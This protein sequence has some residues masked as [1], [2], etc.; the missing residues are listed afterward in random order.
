MATPDASRDKIKDDPFSQDPWALVVPMKDFEK[1]VN[2]TK[3]SISHKR[4]VR[5]EK[6]LLACVAISPRGA[7]WIVTVGQAET[8]VIWRLKDKP[9]TTGE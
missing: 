6:K 3:M 8:I 7:K 9:E 1:C 2:A 5:K 4:S